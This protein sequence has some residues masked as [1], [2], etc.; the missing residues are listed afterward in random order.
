MTAVNSSRNETPDASVNAAIPSV[1]TNVTPPDVT[2]RGLTNKLELVPDEQARNQLLHQLANISR[3]T[4]IGFLN[5]HA[6]N[7]SWN[8]IETRRSF[9]AANSLLRDGAGMAVLCRQLGLD[10]GLNMNGTDFIPDL[11]TARPEKQVVLFGS[12]ATAS[13]AAANALR[14]RGI[15]VTA[16]LDGF[17]TQPSYIAEACRRKP[18]IIILGMGMPQQEQIAVQL[19]DALEHPCLIVNGG[20]IIDFLAKRIRRAP[21]LMQN[22]GLEWSWRLFNEPVRLFSRYIIGNPLF[23]VRTQTLVRRDPAL[24]RAIKNNRALIGGI[25]IASPGGEEGRG[26]MGTVTKLMAGE[27]RKRFPDC[28]VTIID[29][30]GHGSIMETPL[31]TMR[32]LLQLRTSAKS[33]ANVLHLQVSERNSFLRK[34]LLALAA[35]K[36]GM[37]VILHHHGAELIPFY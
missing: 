15:N 4:I 9:A 11:L 27:F 29:P 23:L 2:V 12:E 7:L 30:R 35:R 22:L 26:G 16:T 14:A 28:P 5:A 25:V 36:L 20:A 10:P 13:A 19:R 34:G 37:T 3:P 18:E 31:N 21:K 32:A 33:G 24:S 17:Q 1:N 6:V 8:N